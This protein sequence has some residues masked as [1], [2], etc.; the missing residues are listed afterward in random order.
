MRNCPHLSPLN[1]SAL[2]AFV[3][4][5]GSDA[6]AYVDSGPASVPGGGSSEPREFG[7]HVRLRGKIF[8]NWSDWDYWD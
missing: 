8:E 5:T 7:G 3:I 4:R 6:V 2:N 1:D